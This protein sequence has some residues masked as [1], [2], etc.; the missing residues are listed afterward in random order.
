L[1][2]NEVIALSDGTTFSYDS[3]GN[4]TQMTKGPNTWVYTYDY[5]SRLT[6]VEKNSAT[7][8]EYVYDG[9]GKRIQVT[10]NNETTTYIY[11]GLN[12]LY[13]ETITGLAAYIYGPTG[14]LA[15]RTAINGESHTF[16]YHTDHLGSTRL[17]TDESHSIVSDVTYQ[18]FGEPTATGEEPYLYTGKEIDATG[19]Y[20][21]GARYY[22]PDLGRFMTRDPLAGKKAIP[23]SL[24]RYAYCANNPITLVDPEGLT[25]RMCNTGTGRCIRYHE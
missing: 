10:E 23:Q 9:E 20:Y 2:V 22:D 16:Y 24:N 17:V 3:N 4:I 1:A 14:L 11:S 15:K 13:E 5:A 7:L 12:I 19:L 6:Q 8:G 18:P 25:Y 21:Y